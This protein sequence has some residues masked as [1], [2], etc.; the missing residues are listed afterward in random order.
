MLG[1]TASIALIVAWAKVPE[2]NVTMLI[3]SGLFAIAGSVGYGLN[4]I[5]AAKKD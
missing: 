1:W 3:A 2:A 4:R 5:A